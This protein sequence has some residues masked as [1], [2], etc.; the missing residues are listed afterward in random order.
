MSQ[1]KYVGRMNVSYDIG[2]EDIV[3][4]H[5]GNHSSCFTAYLKFLKSTNVSPIH[6]I[7][8]LEKIDNLLLTEKI[9]IDEF[10]LS[11]Q[12]R[13]VRL[14]RVAMVLDSLFRY[15]GGEKNEN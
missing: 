1:K 5:S 15:D 13:N 11:L 6:F 2:L 7:Q 14:S 3:S 12:K 4:K 9:T 8:L 10:I